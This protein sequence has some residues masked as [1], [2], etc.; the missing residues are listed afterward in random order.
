M[1][2]AVVATLLLMVTFVASL[3]PTRQ[4]R[5]RR[6]ADR[7]QGGLRLSEFV[8][9]FYRPAVETVVLAFRPAP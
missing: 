1:M 6:A 2:Y 9:Q 3:L 8:V 7:A 4:R 5:P